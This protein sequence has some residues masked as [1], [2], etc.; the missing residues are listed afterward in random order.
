MVIRASANLVLT[1]FGWIS[2]Y[3]LILTQRW[4]LADMT[5]DTVLVDIALQGGGAHGAFSW[6]VLDRLLEE[7]WLQIEGISGTSAGAM[8]AAAL[9]SGYVDDGAN[10]ARAALELFWR[11]V[12]QAARL[13]PLQ[14]NP[15]DALMGRWTLDA[16]P[17]FVATDIMSRLF[18]PYDLNPRGVNPLREILAEA[19]S[20][21]F[22]GMYVM[23]E[24]P[25]QSDP[26]QHHVIAAMKNME[27]VVL[28]D[29]FL[30]ETSK[31]AH[32]LLPRLVVAGEGRHLHQRRAPRL[33]RP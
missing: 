26:N 8:N 9:I 24:D 6:G 15:I 13:S 14:R 11:R 3:F 30:N 20:G 29:L 2:I 27:C 33:A 17:F 5:R 4:S 23:G 10:G 18:S 12:S 1:E 28:H 31:Y 25:V 16:S 7:P 21:A 32:R 19:V 22:K